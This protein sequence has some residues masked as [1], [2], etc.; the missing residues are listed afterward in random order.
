MRLSAADA[1]RPHGDHM[2]TNRIE[3]TS[4][5]VIPVHVVTG[6]DSYPLVTDDLLEHVFEELGGT[7]GTV[8]LANILTA[9]G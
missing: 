7:G 4:D 6:A 1:D 5:I 9:D 2:R 8:R 3:K